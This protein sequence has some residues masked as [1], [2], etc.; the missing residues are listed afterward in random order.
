MKI[1]TLRAGVTHAP[2]ALLL[3]LAACE[4]AQEPDASGNFEA[5]EVVVSAKMP[6]LLLRF[7]AEEGEQLAAG[8][9]V[10][11]VD[12]TQLSLE[13]KQL[14]TQKSASAARA[15]SV[16]SQV[17]ALELQRDQARR[18]YERA[19]TLLAGGAIAARDLDSGP[20]SVSTMGRQRAP[21]AA[22]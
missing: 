15:S 18:E 12:T 6:G 4:K 2:L 16:G 3:A 19:Q 1:P 21:C 11:V 20:T 5:E 9:L 7:D 22:S 10:A 17:T 8:A 13:R 14:A